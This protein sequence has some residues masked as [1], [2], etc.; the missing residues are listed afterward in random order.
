MI[1]RKGDIVRA[2][3]EEKVMKKKK[4][5]LMGARQVLRA[6]YAPGA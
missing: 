2:I 3:K 4:G 1:E 5:A 6:Q